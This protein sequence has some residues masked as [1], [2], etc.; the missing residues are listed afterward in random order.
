[1]VEKSFD[2]AVPLFRILVVSSVLQ[3][4]DDLEFVLDT[5]LLG[6]GVD[7]FYAV[8][9]VPLV[10]DR[11][12]PSRA[13]GNLHHV[14]LALL[15]TEI[16]LTGSRTTIFF[17]SHALTLLKF[18]SSSPNQLSRDAHR[19]GRDDKCLV[20]KIFVYPESALLLGRDDSQLSVVPAAGHVH[21]LL[22][23]LLQRQVEPSTTLL[24]E[25]HHTRRSTLLRHLKHYFRKYA[26]VRPRSL[27]SFHFSYKFCFLQQNCIY[28]I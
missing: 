11:D 5:E 14:R 27:K 7:Q 3:I 21:H 23:G 18:C 19:L 6:Y 16:Y 8:T 4:G 25:S 28:K 13:V 2:Q 12:A 15:P 26:T 10:A 1:M 22:A 17:K 24:V 9:L 20:L